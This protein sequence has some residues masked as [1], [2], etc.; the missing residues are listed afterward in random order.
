MSHFVQVLA[1]LKDLAV[2]VVAGVGV[3]VYSV[4]LDLKSAIAMIQRGQL[5]PQRGKFGGRLGEHER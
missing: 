5:F 2:L 3:R 4:L 1:V